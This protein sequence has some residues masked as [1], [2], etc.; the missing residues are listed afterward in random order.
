MCRQGS[1]VAMV[2]WLRLD[3]G[4]GVGAGAVTTRRGGGGAG[5][6][7]AGTPPPPRRR[8]RGGALLLAL[9]ALLL[10]TLLVCGGFALAAPNSPL[11]S[12]VKNV[13]GGGT[14]SATVTIIPASQ[15]VQSKFA[16]LAVTGT[17]NS[18]QRQ[19]QA[20]ELS[21][22]T[23]VQSKTVNATGVGNIPATQ[24]KGRLTFYNALT[25]SQTIG[26]GTTFNVG[27]VQITNNGPAVIPA[28]VPPTEGSV[29]VSAHA[30]TAGANGN[31]RAYA[32][33]GTC[34]VSGVTVQNT[35]A[36]TGGQNAQH[37]TIVQQSD[38]DNVANPLVN[39]TEK[40]ALSSVRAQRHSNEQFVG[41]PQCTPNVR[42]NP[43]AGSKSSTVTVSVSAT[44]AGEVYD[45]SGA[46]AL[47][48]S[49]LQ[50][51]ASKIP[52]TSYKLVGKIETGISQISVIDNKGTVSLV[53]NAAGVWEY[54][55]GTAQKLQ[56]AQL[57]AG[58]SQQEAQG[59]LAAQTGVGKV[60][61]ITISSGTTLPTDPK[62]ITI[63]V[64]DVSGLTG[65][66]PG[67]GSPTTITPTVGPGTPQSGAG[68]SSGSGNG[69]T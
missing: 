7:G 22:T 67:S 6:G 69:T 68:S 3:L 30:I 24:A 39:P 2:V 55:F 9:I 29:S 63:V 41:Q 64:Q 11:G 18:G 32:I 28:A 54:N 53:V 21:Y 52:G 5:A 65:P 61:S 31:I 16:V 15:T 50:H 33:N 62:Q 56:L 60:A 13:V 38:I 51:Q 20:R 25:F 58:K 23:P 12:A 26:A 37:Y 48:V 8:R 44:C 46:V 19:V 40:S 45:Q 42:A 1:K 59:I 34:C 43:S 49:S 17:P 10:L 36:F 66:P 14:P 47:A 4:A 35:S 57:I 27:G